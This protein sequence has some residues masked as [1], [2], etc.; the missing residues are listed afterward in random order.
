[1]T[2]A[3]PQQSATQRTAGVHDEPRQRLRTVPQRQQPA[4]PRRPSTHALHHERERAHANRTRTPHS[5]TPRHATPPSPTHNPS[6]KP[7]NKS[8]NALTWMIIPPAADACASTEWMNTLQSWKPIERILLWISCAGGTRQ[9][10]FIRNSSSSRRLAP[11]HGRTRA[12]RAH[13]AR[14]AFASR[15]LASGSRSHNARSSLRGSRLGSLA[16]ARTLA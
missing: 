5:S 15:T 6:T 13:N 16:L 8:N 14:G 7:Q 11:E 9:R 12:A 10:S 2:R 3:G 4:N 1:M